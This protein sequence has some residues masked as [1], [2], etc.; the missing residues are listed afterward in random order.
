P[1][2]IRVPRSR[3][4]A[5]RSSSGL[6]IPPVEVGIAKLGIAG[7]TSL[8]VALLISGIGPDGVVTTGPLGRAHGLGPATVVPGPSHKASAHASHPRDMPRVYGLL[9][10]ADHPELQGRDD[11]GGELDRDLVLAERLDRLL[12]LDRAVIDLDAGALELLG[13]VAVGDRAEQL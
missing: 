8:V 3:S 6:W 2:R 1:T 12:E 11:A 7:I 9:V 13:D 10:L 5:I 4:P